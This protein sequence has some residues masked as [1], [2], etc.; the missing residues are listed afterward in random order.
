M[1][2]SP[3]E[4][5][6]GVIDGISEIAA[7]FGVSWPDLIAQIICFSVVALVLYK[8]AFKPVLATIEERRKTVAD[9]LR[10]AEEA[11]R[12]LAEARET[13]AAE[14]RDAALEARKL[15]DAAAK[16]AAETAAREQAAAAERANALVE[17]A[18]EAVKLEKQKALDE[19]R[20][21]IARLVVETTRK[22]LARELDDAERERYNAAAARELTQ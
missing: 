18:R 15:I 7:G 5:A 17:R 19:A 11:R 20:A 10:D 2:Q 21:E 14:R 4:P 12:Q 8:F 1:A 22:V 13:I 6:K 3:T 9:G 16:A